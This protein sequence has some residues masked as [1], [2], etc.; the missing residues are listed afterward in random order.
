[1]VCYLLLHE[2]LY[3]SGILTTCAYNGNFK[4]HKFDNLGI[5]VISPGKIHFSDTLN[6]TK[7]LTAFRLNS[8]NFFRLFNNI[9]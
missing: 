4:Y 2:E 6:S 8:L 1:M 9:Y 7:C 3:L 5:N